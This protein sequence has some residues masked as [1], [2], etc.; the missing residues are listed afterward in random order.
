MAP[1]AGPCTSHPPSSQPLAIPQEH[2]TEA[3]RVLADFGPIEAAKGRVHALK[4][5]V[6]AFRKVLGFANDRKAYHEDTIRAAEEILDKGLRDMALD[7]SADP[8]EAAIEGAW[9]ETTNERI[10]ALEDKFRPMGLV[11]GII[12]SGAAQ[13]ARLEALENWRASLE[14]SPALVH[15][16]GAILAM[17]DK[18]AHPEADA[19]FWAILKPS[20]H[21]PSGGPFPKEAPSVE[22]APAGALDGRT[23]SAGRD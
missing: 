6:V 13:L 5:A 4:L 21:P 1:N 11:D 3:R 2:M 22:L 23:Q 17:Q 7:A 10:D 16:P 20:A 19:R 15:S 9:L 14:K 8:V 18:A 12:S